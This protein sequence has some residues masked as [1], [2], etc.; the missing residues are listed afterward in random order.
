VP[1][2]YFA[3]LILIAGLAAATWGDAAAGPPSRPPP[4]SP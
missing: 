2:W 3:S 4:C 1:F